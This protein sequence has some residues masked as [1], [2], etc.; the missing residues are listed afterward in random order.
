MQDLAR[1]R[2]FQRTWVFALAPLEVPEGQYLTSEAHREA[3]GYPSQVVIALKKKAK[4][5]YVL[6]V[7]Y[8]CVE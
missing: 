2:A 6:H 7:V 4:I 3:R 8:S 1:P 5:A